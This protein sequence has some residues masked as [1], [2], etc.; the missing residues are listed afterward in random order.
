MNHLVAEPEVAFW[1]SILADH[2]EFACDNLGPEEEAAVER[3]E[4]LRRRLAGAPGE[5][6]VEATVT[7]AQELIAFQRQLLHRLLA[8]RVVLHLRPVDLSHMIKEAEEF[9]RLAGVLPLPSSPVGRLLHLHWFWLEDAAHHSPCIALA[10]DPAERALS[11]R[12]RYLEKLLLDL[13]LKARR[14]AEVLSQT[15]YG[16]AAVRELTKESRRAIESHVAEL[17]R[18]KE[19]ILRCELEIDAKPVVPD[20][21]IREERYYLNQALRLAAEVLPP[22]AGLEAGPLVTADRPAVGGLG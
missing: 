10:L 17:E 20:H 13:S 19:G 14:Q 3:A 6:P 8:G 16:P 15:G 22:V 18:L 11:E 5:A 7:E 2:A 21:L 1:R 9:L 4:E 12:Y